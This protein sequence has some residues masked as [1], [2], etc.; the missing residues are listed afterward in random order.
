MSRATTPFTCK[1]KKWMIVLGILA[2]NAIVA[3]QAWGIVGQAE[4]YSEAEQEDLD[5][6]QRNLNMEE[7]QRQLT[8][9][10]M[11]TNLAQASG[12]KTEEF[13]RSL[14]DLQSQLLELP[15][16][17]RIRFEA[18]GKY[19][20][21]SNI[22]RG[23]HPLEKD[24]SLF[25]TDGTVLFDLSGKKTDL[26]WE[27]NSGRHWSWEFPEGDFWTAEE[28]L[29]YRRKYFKK[30]QHSAQSRIARHSSKTVEINTNKIRWD[31]VQI[32]AM[33]YPITPKL[34]FNL[35]L[36]SNIRTFTQEAFD[37]DSS[38]EFS[39]APNAFWNFTPKTRISGGYRLGVNRIRTKSGD[40]DSHELHAGYFGKIT[41]KSSASLDVAFT[42]QKPRSRDTATVN[43]YTVGTG[44]IWQM[45]PKTQMTVQLIRSQQN[46]TSDLVSGGLDGG[47]NV[48]VK[49]D[50]HFTNNSATLSLN[51]RLSTKFTS[52]F[53]FNAS[54]S[55]TSVLKDGQKDSETTQFLFPLSWSGTYFI[56]RWISLTLGYT[57][58]YRT[59]YEHAD[60]FKS[61][62]LQTAVRIAI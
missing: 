14:R 41:R 43:T 19:Q 33:N 45:T 38:W 47:E 40:S 31:S 62:L 24:D 4:E 29:R 16:R 17:R 35:D 10:Q 25:D 46:S 34:S 56:R 50:S 58:T 8:S 5:E 28:R 53:S 42:H 60:H 57:F 21:D 49:N 30:L 7:Q 2:A 37:Q 3:G 32:T 61:H 59:G 15:S 48:T 13:D 51:T 9:L 55:K 39:T 22:T 27:L 6:F 36:N 54:H 18:N 11:R 52:I 12:Q 44:Y 23:F 26:R 1:Q 20:F